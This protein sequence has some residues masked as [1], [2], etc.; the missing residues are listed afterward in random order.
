MHQPPKFED[1]TH[2]SHVRRLRKAIYGMKQAPWA[3]YR[4]LPTYLLSVGFI[5]FNSV[6]SLFRLHRSGLIVYLLVYVDDII[7]TRNKSDGVSVIIQGFA[8]QFSLNNLG[9]LNYFLGVQ[10]P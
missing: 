7:V 9:P 2:P 4:E 3:W 5:I 8:L 1:S 10:V 6:L